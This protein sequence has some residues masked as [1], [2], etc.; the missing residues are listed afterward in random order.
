MRGTPQ[1][2]NAR[3]FALLL[4]FAPFAGLIES[5]PESPIQSQ[6]PQLEVGAPNRFD[7]NAVWRVNAYGVVLALPVLVSVLLMSALP[8]GLLSALLPIAGIV[9]GAFFLP[10]GFGNRLI[11]RLV[12]EQASAKPGPD[13]FIV[14]A[15]FSPR[16]RSGLRS[17]LEDADD[18]GLLSFS[19]AE[20][21]FKG[22]SASLRVPFRCLRSVQQQSLGL[23]G[24]FAYGN[25]VAVELDG[26]PEL[27]RVAF[28]E[29]S[30]LIIPT[31]WKVSRLIHA[32]MQGAMIARNT[33]NPA[34]QTE[35]KT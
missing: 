6:V 2:V 14:Q 28:A 11:T 24:L 35:A 15:T 21:V 26:L 1:T 8:F 10:F 22:D 4:H 30:S 3:D 17:V 33:G 23:R 32:K 27:K 25:R 5:V 7:L 34:G 18:V 9:L 31:S 20:F 19:A 13:Q 29:R 16:I 12:R